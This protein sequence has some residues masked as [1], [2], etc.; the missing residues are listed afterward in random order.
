MKGKIAA[1]GLALAVASAAAPAQGFD[2]NNLYIGGGISLNSASGVDDEMGLQVFVGY[3]LD[4]ADLDPIKLAVEVGYMDIDDYNV[5]GLWVTGV[6]TYALDAQ[7]RLLGRLGF[8]FGDDDG[9]MVG[10]GLGYAFNRQVE[11]RGEYVV[12]DNIDSLQANVV[13]RF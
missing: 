4:M 5:S 12:R 13:Y 2:R 6:A 1:I 8:D 9:L 3:E 11:V 10:A 7:F